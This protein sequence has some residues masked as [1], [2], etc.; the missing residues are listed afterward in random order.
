MVEIDGK[1]HDHQ[2]ER[3][4]YREYI[5]EQLGMTVI[6]FTNE[7]VQ[8][9]LEGVVQY[10]LENH[11][12]ADYWIVKLTSTGE[13]DWQKSL[14]VN[15]SEIPLS[16]QQTADSGYIIAGYCS[17]DSKNIS[18]GPYGTNE[19]WIVKLTAT[20]ETAWQKSF[21]GSECDRAYSIK[22]TYDGGYIIAGFT[23]SNNR[24]V[25]GNNGKKDYWRTDKIRSF[26]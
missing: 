24:D 13:I 14:G 1:I 11:G 19:Y 6:R 4:R 23:L 22:Q 20:G 8:K 25:S 21:G 12:N 5:I 26:S 17:C 2:I 3:D 7:E 18:E 15:G 10:V 16:L 9:D